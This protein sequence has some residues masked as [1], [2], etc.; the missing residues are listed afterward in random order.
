[1][2]E[3]RI[4]F[5]GK[6]RLFCAM[7]FAGVFAFFLLDMVSYKKPISGLDHIEFL[8]QIDSKL[9]DSGAE[10]MKNH[11]VIFTGITRDNGRDI[12]TMLAVFYKIG[13]MFEDYRVVVFENDSSDNTLK[14][15]KEAE[16]RDSKIKIISKKFNLKKMPSIKFIA[17]IRNQY[18]REIES[19]EYD[20]FDI[21]II[22]DMDMKYGIDLRAIKHSFSIIDEWEAVCS[23]GIF[24]RDGRMYDAFAFR[25]DEFFYGPNEVGMEWYLRKIRPSAQKIYPVTGNLIKVSSCFGGMAIYK[26]KYIRG[27]RYDSINEDCEHVVFHRCIDRENSG[28]M[29]MNPVQIIRY[30]HYE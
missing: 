15:L 12:P 14:I 7:I 30:E 4:F 10:E 9:F 20:D 27:C 26:K 29:Y 19:K 17:D 2:V 22:F 6:F 13:S 25:N 1:M 3:M 8:D 23:N 24:T 28:R 21:V 11:K 18:L 5:K 16:A